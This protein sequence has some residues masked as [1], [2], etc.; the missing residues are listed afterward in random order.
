[1]I[2]NFNDDLLELLKDFYNLTHMK[3]C[4]YDQEGNE[5]S[6]YP[7]RFTKFCGYIREFKEIDAK[8]RLCDKE[9]VDYCKK[10]K[11]PHIYTC[12]GGLTECIAPI[13]VNEK[14]NG[15]I[16][17]VQI[18]EKEEC[19]VPDKYVFCNRQKAEEYYND[20]EII[21]RE[22]IMSALH[23]LSACAGYEQLRRFVLQEQNSFKLKLEDYIKTN[24]SND[25]GVNKLCD[26]FNISR[27][28]LYRRIKDIYNCTP[29]ELIKKRRLEKAKELLL[30]NNCKISCIAEQCGLGDYNYFSKLF[31]KEFAL[32]PKN[33]KNKN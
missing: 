5:I 10:T 2:T 15:Y 27:V 32:S 11:K 12:H 13:L 16:V 23:V 9:A 24:L 19:I 18:R 31:K 14:I 7:D 29:A 21:P 17:L 33:Y 1:M 30:E 28:E 25:L 22:T 6:Y 26:V 20:L 8:C 3:I 4:V